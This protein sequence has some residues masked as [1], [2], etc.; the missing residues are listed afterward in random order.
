MHLE[1][2]KN[3]HKMAADKLISVSLSSVLSS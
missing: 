3:K 2:T 1:A